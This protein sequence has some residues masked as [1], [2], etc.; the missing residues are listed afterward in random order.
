MKFEIPFLYN[1]TGYAPKQRNPHLYQVLGYQT[2][3][4]PEIDIKDT[5]HIAQLVYRDSARVDYLSVNGSLLKQADISEAGKTGVQKYIFNSTIGETKQNLINWRTNVLAQRIKN[6][7]NPFMPNY[8][9]SITEKV[10]DERNLQGVRLISNDREKLIQ[11]LIDLEKQGAAVIAGKVYQKT[12]GPVIELHPTKRFDRSAVLINYHTEHPRYIS[13]NFKDIYIS[14]FTSDQTILNI[15]RKFLNKTNNFEQLPTNQN[16]TLEIFDQKS[17]IDKSSDFVIRDYSQK[18]ISDMSQ[19]IGYAPADIVLQFAHLKTMIQESWKSGTCADNRE[20]LELA[21]D[22]DYNYT[23]LN[24]G[25]VLE[26]GQNAILWLDQILPCVQ[27][28]IDPDDLVVNV[29]DL[30]ELNSSSFKI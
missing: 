17:I 22:L 7:E 9:T 4:L 5:T 12:D 20:M 6:P 1:A 11:K 24:S 26:G 25:R 16:F 3:D 27:S 28:Y 23:A 15:Q 29:D 14:A 21:R 2:V 13:H 8:F 18:L 19:S 10:L 30:E